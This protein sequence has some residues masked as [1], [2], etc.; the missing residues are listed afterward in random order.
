[1]KQNLS[2][3]TKAAQIAGVDWK[4]SSVEAP[5]RQGPVSSQPAPLSALGAPEKLVGPWSVPGHKCAPTLSCWA[6]LSR[7]VDGVMR[8][9]ILTRVQTTPS[10]R[11]SV[12]LRP[13]AA[14]HVR[15][16]VRRV[17]S[18]AGDSLRARSPGS[19]GPPCLFMGLWVGICRTSQRVTGFFV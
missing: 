4:D 8:Q 15:P 16:L 6:F 18:Q 9:V 1:M 7:R 17:L 12:A 5:L 3:A 11:E 14:C 10:L 13:R 2:S 19:H